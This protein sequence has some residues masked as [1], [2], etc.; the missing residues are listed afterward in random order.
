MPNVDRVRIKEEIL[1]MMVEHGMVGPYEETCL[2]L[3]WEVDANQVER[4]RSTNA[5]K[6]EELEGKIKDAEGNLGEM[7]VRDALVAKANFLADIGDQVQALDAFDVAE[8]KTAGSG[9]K[10]DLS[11]ARMRL[12]MA[13]G[14]WLAIKKEMEQAEELCAQG[15]DWERK[16]RLKV[17]KAIYFAAT[18]QF[19]K[20]SELF[21]ESIATFTATELMSFKQCVFYTVALA[22]VAL[23]RSAVKSSVVENPE[24]LSV[25]DTLPNLRQFVES[26]YHSRYDGYFEAFAGLTDAIR[27]D[28][29]LYPHFRYYM[30]EARV[31]AY[32]Q[33]L[34]SYKSVTLSSMARAF[35][36]T[37]EF[38]DQDL[39]DFIVAGRVCAKIDR[40]SHIV[41]TLRPDAKNS[42]Y[43]NAIRQGDHLLNKLQKLSKV[44]DVE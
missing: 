6:L 30:R 21:L 16:N 22:V 25:I 15:G 11:F 34:E 32:C 31:V 7:E 40:V 26:L 35:G 3:G 1:G 41:E 9:P 10:L 17:Y 29:F 4:M 24:I 27:S 19:S 20:A 36:V 8:R 43:Q 13:R 37:P 14:D 42:M 28:R 38:I 2:E 33:F 44:V 39:A 23:D 12:F 18:R 5:S